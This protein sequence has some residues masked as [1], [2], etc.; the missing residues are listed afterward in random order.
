MSKGKLV[1]DLTLLEIK[2]EVAHEIGLADKIRKY[3]WSGLS[4]KEA[5]RLGGLITQRIRK[6]KKE[7]EKAKQKKKEA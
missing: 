3:G 4:A 1:D 2:L 6:M 7:E 5:G